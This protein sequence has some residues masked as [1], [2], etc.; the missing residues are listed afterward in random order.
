[1]KILSIIS[2]LL[3]FCFIK[4]SAQKITSAE[5]QVNG[6]TCSMCSQAT[7]KSLRTLNYVSSVKPDLN[8]NLFVLTF[9]NEAVSIDQLKN[10]VEDAGFSVG[11]L[12]TEMAFD[13]VKV[14][15][16]GQAQIGNAVY[17]FVNVKNKTLNGPVKVTII[18]KSFVTAPVFKSWAGKISS[19]AYKTGT[20]VVKGKKVRVYHVSV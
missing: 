6:L 12:T 3:C 8:K 2:F 9:K 7:E 17:R 14:D 19:D 10:K 16:N 13:N 15:A 18:D 1:M 20:T 5:I 11:R 4:V